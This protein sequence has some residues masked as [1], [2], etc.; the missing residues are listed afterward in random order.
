MAQLRQ[1]RPDYGLDC[2]KLCQILALTVSRQ[3][4]DGLRQSLDWLKLYREPSV[5]GHDVE[6]ARD[7][8]QRDEHHPR[9]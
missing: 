9:V 6:D 1:S 3:S 4:L 2:L 8:E 7:R 5:A